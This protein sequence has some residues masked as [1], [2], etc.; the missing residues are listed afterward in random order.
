MNASL[1]APD[2]TLA[3]RALRRYAAHLKRVSSPFPAQ[4]ELL[5]CAQLWIDISRQRLDAKAWRLLFELAR[6]RKISA[7]IRA[8]YAGECVN[9]TEARP[10]LHMA[11][12]DG[13][14]RDVAVPGGFAQQLAR[15]ERKRMQAFVEGVHAGAITGWQGRRIERVVHIGIG[16]SELGPALVCDALEGVRSKRLSVRFLSTVDDLHFARVLSG[17]DPAAT[18]FLI[19]S[20]SFS[21]PETIA[22]AERV[23][24]W[25]QERLGKDEAVRQQLVAITAHP[26]KAEAMGIA[27]ERIFRFWDWVGGRFSLWSAV[28]LPIAL[29]F[30]WDVFEQL[31]AGARALDHHFATA[32]L[33]RNIPLR[34]ALIDLWNANMLG[35]QT[36]AVI[37]YA[38]ALARLVPHLQQLVMES[39]GKRTRTNGAPVR[40]QTSPVLWGGPG[41]NTQ[42]AFFQL[43]H[44]SPQPV[45]V[46]F[47][48]VLAACNTHEELH[49]MQLANCLAQAEALWHGR[50]EE[51]ARAMLRREGC[52]EEE[53]QRLAPHLACAGGRAVTLIALDRLAPE[54]IGMLLALY[55]H[56][57]FAQAA[58]WD[59]NA[60]DQWGV[61]LGKRLA[62]DVLAALE[63]RRPAPAS[64]RC[65]IERIRR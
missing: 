16:G 24:S 64:L 11:L 37:P 10:A 54:T 12:R 13:L 28:G 55:E 2:C 33:L 38:Q 22:N 61:E 39:C 47:V 60:F 26:A 65:W 56:R 31:L 30:G 21:T 29:K 14:L 18:L 63:G 46:E 5:R 40:W 62:R 52:S 41:T 42:H 32:S 3:W 51:E 20:K 50:S 27:P 19:A 6:Q 53:A 45:P 25:L 7:Q 44:Q 17:I 57:T 15:A 8:L 36:L 43:L 23:R 49:R 9:A 1:P 58:L 48:L 59:I 4:V 34:L 35:A